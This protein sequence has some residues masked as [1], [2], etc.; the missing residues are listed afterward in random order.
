MIITANQSRG[1]LVAIMQTNGDLRGVFD[2]VRVGQ[3]ITIRAHDNA[4]TDGFR[5]SRWSLGAIRTARPAEPRVIWPLELEK[6]L[7]KFRYLLS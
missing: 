1:E 3:D 4:R 6:T 2:D 5:L 7:E